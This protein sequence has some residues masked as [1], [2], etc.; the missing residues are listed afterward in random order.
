MVKRLQLERTRNPV[1][2]KGICTGLLAVTTTTHCINKEFI[3]M[4]TC[5]KGKLIRFVPPQGKSQMLDVRNDICMWQLPAD[6]KLAN[7]QFHSPC[8]IDLL[9][10]AEEFF[11]HLEIGKYQHGLPRLQNIKLGY[12]LSGIIHSYIKSHEYDFGHMA[13]VEDK[14]ETVTNPNPY[15]TQH[16]GVVWECISTIKF[17]VVFNASEKTTNGISLKDLLMQLIRHEAHNYPAESEITARDFHVDDLISGTETVEQALEIQQEFIELMMGSFQLCKWSSNLWVHW[18]RCHESKW[19]TA[20]EEVMSEECSKEQRGQQ[21]SKVLILL[22]HSIKDLLTKFSSWS[23]F[24]G[25]T[26]YCENNDNKHHGNLK[27]SELSE[28]VIL[29]I[30]QVQAEVFMRK[31]HDLLSNHTMSN[32]SSLKSLSPF[33]DGRNFPKLVIGCVVLIKDDNLPP[34]VWKKGIAT[35]VVAIKT[36]T[37][38]LKIPVDKLCR[39]PMID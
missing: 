25:V 22:C 30:K 38:D 16:H 32:K 5:Y 34:L 9:I 17:R 24:Q 8:D 33:L 15:Y 13:H 29:R 12:I 20:S 2:I 39:I 18:L 3:S 19:P 27:V 10:G 1:H 4:Y 23:R 28:A 37:G 6:M 11:E 31:I 7:Y 26:A 35:E 21:I 14:N 36:V